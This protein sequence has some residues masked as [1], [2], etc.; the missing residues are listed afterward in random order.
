MPIRPPQFTP[1]APGA[2]VDQ[3]FEI[4]LD[5]I[6]SGDCVSSVQG[7]ATILIS[8]RILKQLRDTTSGKWKTE[9]ERLAFIRG[10]RADALLQSVTK[11]TDNFGC[12]KVRKHVSDESLYLISELLQSGQLAVIDNEKNRRV[13]HIIVNFKGFRVGLLS[14]IGHISYLFTRESVPFLQLS[15]WVS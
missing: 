14:G 11:S 10:S 8:R 9:Q 6:P 13:R 5:A 7:Q 1:P 15:W 2:T 3:S 12:A 4:T